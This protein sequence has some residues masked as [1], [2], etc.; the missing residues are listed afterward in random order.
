MPDLLEQRAR[1][2]HKVIL[3]VSGMTCGSCVAHVEKALRAV[4]GVRDAA[5]N[6]ATETAVVTLADPGLDAREL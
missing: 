2:D 5:V 1:T 6:L 4:E 3:R